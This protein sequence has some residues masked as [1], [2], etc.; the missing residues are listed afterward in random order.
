MKTTTAVLY[1]SAENGPLPI[2]FEMPRI[3]YR[4]FVRLCQRHPDLRVERTDEGKLLFMPPAEAEGDSRNTAITTL[5]TLWNWSLPEPGKTFGPSAGF[6]LPSGTTRSPDA[7]WISAERWIAL[8]ATERRGF[9]HICPDFVV[10]LLSP[11]DSLTETQAKLTEY[12]SNGAR[13]GLIIDRKR[14]VVEVYRPGQPTQ[15]LTNPTE[16]SCEPELSGFI[17]S[18]ERVF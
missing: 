2:A 10:E 15:T 14:H 1:D 16:V 9:A 13:L 3:S 18:L 7:A 6:T 12:L 5:L 17:L 11:S 8:T 4:E